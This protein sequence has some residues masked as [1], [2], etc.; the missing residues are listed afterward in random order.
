MESHFLLKTQTIKK[1]ILQNINVDRNNSYFD[2]NFNG[3][4]KDPYEDLYT[5][6][7]ATLILM[8]IDL[9]QH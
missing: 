4:I 2:I 8:G 7:Y 6:I 1:Y 9:N 5:I 3:N